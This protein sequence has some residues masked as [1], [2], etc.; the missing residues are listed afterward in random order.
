MIRIILL[1]SCLILQTLSVSSLDLGQD[2]RMKRVVSGCDEAYRNIDGTC[3]NPASRKKALLASTGRPQFSYF[4]ISNTTKPVARDLPS[5]RAVSNMLFMSSSR[6]LDT[7][8]LNQFSVFFGTFLGNTVSFTPVNE[9][10]PLPI[11]VPRNDPFYG[12]AKPLAF[13]RSNRALLRTNGRIVVRP[14]NDMTS[15]VDLASVYGPSKIRTN[16]V[17]FGR[18]GLM[19]TSAGDLLPFNTFRSDNIPSKSEKFFLGGDQRVNENPVL[20]SIH[21]LFVREHNSLAKELKKKFPGWNDRFLFE[22]ARRINVAQMQKIVFKEWYPAFIGSELPKYKGFKTRVDATVSLLFSTVGLRVFNSMLSGSFSRRGPGNSK[23]SSTPFRLYD[24]DTVVKP[25]Q[26]NGIQS[27]L[28]G[29]L[30]SAAAK[31]DLQISDAIRNY[32]RTDVKSASGDL[33]AADLQRGRDHGIPRFNQVRKMLGLKQLNINK[34]AA[35]KREGMALKR[36]YGMADSVEALVGV[37]AEKRAAK[38]SFGSTFIKL[39]E[40]EM[41]RIRDG[42]FFYFENNIFS[43]ELKNKIPRVKALFTSKS[44]MKAIL[45]RN[46]VSSTDRPFLLR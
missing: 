22:E 1:L 26:K 24:F 43:K 8:G 17:L 19:K 25:L 3:T 32:P 37:L 36:V 33:V 34:I 2:V 14:V 20:A 6:T 35:G 27:F 38:S 44:V 42:D 11:D 41:T 39:W 4:G 28:R 45:E 30:M 13:C 16:A 15:A 46:G 10:E 7:R 18:D 40:T 29:S 5:P 21:T 31:P 9:L 23:L 12:P